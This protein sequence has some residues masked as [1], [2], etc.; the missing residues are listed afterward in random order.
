[1]VSYLSEGRIE[2][3]ADAL[4]DEF[5]EASGSGLQAPVPI[6]DIVEKHLKLGIEFDDLHRRFGAP[7]SVLALGPDI[8]G[9]I[10]L[11][12]RRIVVDEF[13]DPDAD[14]SKEG[15][16][17]F[18]VAHEVGHWRLHRGLM[19]K[20]IGNV[21]VEDSPQAMVI[22]RSS[23]AKARVELQADIFASCLLMPRRLVHAAWIAAFA[24]G[25]P[26][27][28]KSSIRLGLEAL[29]I[30]D[31]RP[32]LDDAEASETSLL[33]RFVDPFAREFSVSPKAMRVR[34]ERLGL[35]LRGATSASSAGRKV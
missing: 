29:P 20:D 34:L 6:D 13:L 32:D 23:E 12:Q 33:D 19:G 11:S 8:I 28:L 4:L 9:A 2:A 21:P 15:R 1:M 24:D 14:P 30:E 31:H 22:C 16:Y 3:D 5:V 7:N 10:F 35:V 18:T 27:A 17:R 26:R 25:R